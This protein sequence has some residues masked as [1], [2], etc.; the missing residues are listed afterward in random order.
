[1]SIFSL[2]TLPMVASSP[3]G[4]GFREIFQSGKGFHRLKSLRSTDL[5]CCL[6]DLQLCWK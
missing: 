2:F 6:S 4:L 5:T 3:T 1:M